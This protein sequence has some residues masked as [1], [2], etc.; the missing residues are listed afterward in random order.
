MVTERQTDTAT[1][2]L[3]YGVSGRSNGVVSPIP[4]PGTEPNPPPTEN[5]A[6]LLLVAVVLLS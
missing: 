3:V 1:P 6:L 4:R 5:V 2:S